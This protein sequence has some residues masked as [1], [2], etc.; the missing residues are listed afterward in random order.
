MAGPKVRAARP[1]LAYGIV[2]RVC[3]LIARLLFAV[4]IEGRENIPT[5][6]ALLAAVPHRNWVE[7]LLLIAIMPSDLRVATIADA[8]TVSGSRS[9]RLLLAAI[10]PI[11]VRPNSGRAGFEAIA[12][13]ASDVMDAG[14]VVAIFPELGTPSPPP[15][16]RRLSSGVGHMAARSRAPVVPIVFGGTHELYLRRPIVVRIL[17]PLAPPHSVDRAEIAGFMSRLHSESERAALAAHKE[18]ESMPPKRKRWR[19]LTGNYPRA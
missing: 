5:S 7:P 8:A 11:P 17:A 18:A 10:G 13:A 16:L 3:A 14:G 19:W 12:S 1:A 4:T 9:R 6:R 2:R 15:R